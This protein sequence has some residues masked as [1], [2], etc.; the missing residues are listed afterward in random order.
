M[1]TEVDRNDEDNETHVSPKIFVG[2]VEDTNQP[3]GI[4]WKG[5]NPSVS[6]P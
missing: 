4:S 2:R 5:T 1:E 6:V 3:K